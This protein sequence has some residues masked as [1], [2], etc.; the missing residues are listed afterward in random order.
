MDRAHDLLAL[1][2]VTH[3]TARGLDPRGEGRFADESVPPHV[4]EELF[5]GDHPIAVDE[6]VGEDVE[7]LWFDRD[8][9]PAPAQ[10]EERRVE[11]GVTKAVDHGRGPRKSRDGGRPRSRARAEVSQMRCSW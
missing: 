6:E 7:H 2:V 9:D 10:L 1:A 8:G 5:L 4:V 11:L 3:R